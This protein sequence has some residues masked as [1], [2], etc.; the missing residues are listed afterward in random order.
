[1][2]GELPQVDRGGPKLQCRIVFRNSEVADFAELC[3]DPGDGPF[4]HRPV[5]PV[6]GPQLLVV[7]P[8]GPVRPLKLVVHIDRD[9]AA[10]R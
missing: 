4:D 2:G 5:R 3:R 8:P 6:V 1:V 9:A 10:L 7:S